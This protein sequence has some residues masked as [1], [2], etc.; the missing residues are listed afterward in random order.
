MQAFGWRQ[1]LWALAAGAALIALAIQLAG[2]DPPAPGAAGAVAARRADERDL[3]PIFA[4]MFRLY[5]PAAALRALWI[6]PWVTQAGGAG[7]ALI[8]NAALFMGLAMV[9]GNLAYGPADRWL[10]RR[11]R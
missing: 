7:T 9:A 5:A 10:A 8:G 11:K 4:M 3:W 2:R 6:T 1:V